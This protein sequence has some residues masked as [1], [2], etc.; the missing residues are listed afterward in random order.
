MQSMNIFSASSQKELKRSLCLGALSL[1][2]LFA[3]SSSANAAYFTL[4]GPVRIDL[5]TPGNVNGVIGTLV[6]VG[7]PSSLADPVDLTAGSVSFESHDVIVFALSL[8]AGSASVDSI[9]AG[10]A[11]API[12]P[13]PMGAG[14][15]NNDSGTGLVS[16]DSV[17][18]G[19]FSTL[20]GDYSFTLDPVEANETTV[21]LFLTYSPLGS[22]LDLGNTIN[23][24]LS[25]GT[26]FSVQSTLVP[27]PGT[28]VLVALGL[29]LLSVVRRKAR[30]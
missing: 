13:N 21:N 26:N 27:E 10:A 30:L 7:L 18:V 22:A 1:P 20:R 3:L 23:F 14:S 25:S 24:T 15:F 6:P 19:S 2:L 4:S 8:N 17:S 5:S 12:L 11:S 16:P 28:S 9:G 29:G